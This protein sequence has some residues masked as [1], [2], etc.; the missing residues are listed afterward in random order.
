V[1]GE[2]GFAVRPEAERR[3]FRPRF[4]REWFA[5]RANPSGKKVDGFGRI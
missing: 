3:F 1:N 5:L 2:R 4:L